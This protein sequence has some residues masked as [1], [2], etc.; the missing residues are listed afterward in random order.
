MKV[1]NFYT[2][3]PYKKGRPKDQHSRPFGQP[4]SSIIDEEPPELYQSTP[5][6][7]ARGFSLLLHR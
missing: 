7:H 1:P 4:L 6:E 2:F 5:Q 3:L